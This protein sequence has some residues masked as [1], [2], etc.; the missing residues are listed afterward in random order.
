MIRAAVRRDGYGHIAELG[1]DSGHFR[2]R[3]QVAFQCRDDSRTI[4][5]QFQG[6]LH[7]GI[8]RS[9]EILEKQRR[10]A[11]GSAVAAFCVE[12]A[13]SLEIRYRR[14]QQ[15]RSPSRSSPIRFALGPSVSIVSSMATRSGTTASRS[16]WRTLTPRKLGSRNARRRPLSV[17][18]LPGECFNW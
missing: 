8:A 10:E 3:I 17:R 14:R 11:T 5:N 1:D 2:D 6:I 16:G 12:I 15:P 9:A 13:I 18:K 4:S 7:V